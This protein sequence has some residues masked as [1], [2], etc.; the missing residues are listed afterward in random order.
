VIASG[1]VNSA[2]A[3]FAAAG[4]PLPVPGARPSVSS[5]SKALAPS[6]WQ[7]QRAAA[8]AVVAAEGV[9]AAQSAESA[10]SA[11]ADAAAANSQSE[12]APMASQS[13]ETQVSS[14]TEA[15]GA[16]VAAAE[17]ISGAFVFPA[18]WQLCRAEDGDTFYL[19]AAGN[20]LWL[21]LRVRISHLANPILISLTLQLCRDLLNFFF[22]YPTA[23]KSST[24]MG[25]SGITAAI[26]RR[27]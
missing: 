8:A 7:Q 13:T 4:A 11:T 20:A 6:K 5:V 2:R 27:R 16:Y 24:E 23:F 10:I 19:D 15:A 22:P 25:Q 9:G 1:T 12:N 26:V 18:G 14:L 3:K 17:D 21:L